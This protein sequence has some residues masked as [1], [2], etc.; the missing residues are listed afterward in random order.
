MTGLRRALATGAVV[1][2]VA[3]TAGPAGAAGPVGGSLRLSLDGFERVNGRAVAL[4]GDRLVVRGRTS[5]FAARQRVKVRVYRGGKKLRVVSRKLSPIKRGGGSFTVAVPTGGTGRLTIRASHRRTRGMGTL[6]ARPVRVTVVSP[7]LQAGSR[8][9]A[10]RLLQSKLAALH[11]VVPRTGVFDGG[12]A[13]AVV[14]FRKQTGM[15]RIFTASREVFLRL[16]AGQGAWQVRFPSHGHHVEADLSRQTL[17]LIDGGRVQRIYHTSSG[18]PGTPTVLGTFHVYSKTP[19]V[20]QKGMVDSS[21]FIRG[22]AIHGYYTVPVFNAS[23]GC[24]RVPTPDARSIF[25]WI[26]YGDVVDVYR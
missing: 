26:R 12:T 6:V 13:R 21:Y 9:P 1:I 10:V 7:Q 8:G 2:G 20:N 24:L 14:A 22:Y 19:G 5:R 25:N 23:H 3:L 18:A 15:R 16:R 11:Y 4:A 17:A